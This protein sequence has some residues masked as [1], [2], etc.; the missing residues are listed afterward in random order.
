[1]NSWIGVDLDG[2]LARYDEW[3]NETHIGEPV[4][5]MVNLVKDWLDAGIT[6]KIFTA[7]VCRIPRDASG[8]RDRNHPVMMAIEAWCLKNIGRVLEVTNEKDYGMIQLWDDRA[9]R[10]IENT[11]RTCCN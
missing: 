4:D 3:V 1:M 9:V 7:R 8:K 6:V 2:T 11:G 5:R 10:V